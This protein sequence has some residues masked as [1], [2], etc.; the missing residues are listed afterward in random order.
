VFNRIPQLVSSMPRGQVS[1]SQSSRPQAMVARPFIQSW[2]LILET[3]FAIK[4]DC[5]KND[6]TWAIQELKHHSL[7]RLFKPVTSTTY[8]RLV[9]SF[10]EKLKYDYNQSGVLFSSINDRDVEVTIGDIVAA[11]KCHAEPPEAEEP[12]IVYPSMLTTKDN[13]LDMCEGQFVEKHKNAASKTKMP[14]QLWFM[15]I[16]LQMNVCPLGHKIQRRDMFLN[17]LY[18]F[19]KGYWCSIPKIIWSQIHKF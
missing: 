14:P 3:T 16:V 18:S 5:S 13:V 6:A 2:K 12:W 7:K 17:A 19:Y 15:D 10:Y 9:L 8:E 1:A 11:L 4:E